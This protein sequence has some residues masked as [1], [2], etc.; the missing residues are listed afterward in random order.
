MST[1]NYIILNHYII[2]NKVP[3]F[4]FPVNFTPISL[5]NFNSQGFLIFTIL[6]VN[7]IV[8][9]HK[10]FKDGNRSVKLPFII[11]TC[12]LPSPELFS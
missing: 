8:S 4:N 1:M 3:P 12:K 11:F 7:D 10:V 6:N 9:S 2:I 5:G